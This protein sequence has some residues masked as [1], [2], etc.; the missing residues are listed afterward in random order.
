[1]SKKKSK[2]RNE[3]KERRKSLDEATPDEIY[4]GCDHWFKI[5]HSLHLPK[6][7]LEDNAAVDAILRERGSVK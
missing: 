7:V 1:M 5:I 3:S 4:D 6:E 2:E